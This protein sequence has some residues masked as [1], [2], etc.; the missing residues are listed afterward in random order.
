M[1]RYKYII[2]VLSV[3]VFVILGIL[4]YANFF[5]EQIIFSLF[6]D[7]EITLYEGSE[8]VEYGYVAVLEN[9]ENLN[10]KVKVTIFNIFRTFI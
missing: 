10:K 8:Y 7:K 6:G 9:G 2:V 1:K 4:I 5:E 3:I